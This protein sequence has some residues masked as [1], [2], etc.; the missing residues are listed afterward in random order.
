M[1]TIFFYNRE[2]K[3]N[4]KVLQGDDANGLE[5]SSV[6]LIEDVIAYYGGDK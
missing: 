1:F 4:H 5:T 6:V 2:K 3:R